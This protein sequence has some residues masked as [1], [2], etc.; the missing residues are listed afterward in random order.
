LVLLPWFGLLAALLLDALVSFRRPPALDLAIPAEIFV[1]DTIDVTLTAERPARQLRVRLDW[2]EGVAGPAEAPFP[3]KSTEQTQAQIQIR[4]LR[5]GAW[6]LTDIWLLWPSRLHLWEFAP[7]LRTN[8]TFRIVPNIRRVQSGEIDTLVRSSLYGSKANQS[9]GDGTEFH[10]LQDFTPGM[11]VKS[12]DWKRSARRRSLVAK[13]MHAERNHNVILCLDTGYLMQQDVAGL[14]RLDHAVT[15]ALAMAWAA[16]IGGDRVGY[17]SYDVRPHHL[18]SPGPGRRSFSRMRSW[19]AELFP[20]PRETNHTLAMSVLNA[21]TPKR[22][23]IVVFTEFIDT[24]SAELLLDTLA[25]LARRHLIVFVAIRDPDL[26]RL[27]ASSPKTMDMAAQ[28][29]SAHQSLAERRLVIERLNRLGVTVI[30]A[31][32]GTITTKLISTYLEIK[33]RELI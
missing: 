16:A 20:E 14:S 4:A 13:D 27:V 12:I 3:S 6:R 21:H 5:R 9:L 32:P 33:T 2:P 24:T 28:I 29:V 7:R 22:S 25:V 17:F 15:A 1:G 18:E 23:L 10:Q 26:D 19:S 11:N 30:D 8:Q 31:R